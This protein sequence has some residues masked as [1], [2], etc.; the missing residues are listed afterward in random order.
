MTPLLEERIISRAYDCMKQASQALGRDFLPPRVL[1]TQR[2]RIAGS[3]W[4]ERWELRFNP[5]L[6]ADNEP[7]FISDIVPHEVAHLVAFACYGKVKPHGQEWQHIMR[8]IF[9]R[10]P[11]TRHQLDISKAAPTFSYQCECR[12][13]QL[14]LRRHNNMLRKKQRYQCLYCNG[15]L[16][17]VSAP[18]AQH[19]TSS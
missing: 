1:F 6:L 14:T 8:S 4:L 18:S 12:R 9:K 15:I 7:E 17:K 19:I 10:V 11:H 3:A 16:K 2:G 5:I 13:H